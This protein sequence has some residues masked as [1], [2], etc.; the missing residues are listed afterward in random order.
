MLTLFQAFVVQS[1]HLLSKWSVQG[2]PN[3]LSL[4]QKLFQAVYGPRRGQL[5][6]LSGVQNRW[7]VWSLRQLGPLK[8]SKVR[9]LRVHKVKTCNGYMAEKCG[10]CYRP[11]AM[12]NKKIRFF[13]WRKYGRYLRSLARAV[14]IHSPNPL[15]VNKSICWPINLIWPINQDAHQRCNS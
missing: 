6:A 3:G 8:Y 5:S 1:I 15:L 14:P 13:R 11:L 7:V 9:L 2:S 10:F 4:L 12:C